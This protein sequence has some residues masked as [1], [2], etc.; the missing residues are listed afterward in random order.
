M[1]VYGTQ[2]YPKIEEITTLAKTF[3]K[4]GLELYMVGGAVRDMVLGRRVKD[5]DFTTNAPPQQ[6]Q[7]LF[8][9]VI[10]TGIDHG[11]VTVLLGK[12][13]FEITTY[14]V[15][16]KYSDQRH[17]DSIAYAGA[18]EEDL[19][20][21]DFTI[22]AM[23]LDPISGELVDLYGGLS[24][25]ESRSIRA[26]GEPA[27]RFAEDPLRVIRGCRFAGQLECTISPATLKAMKEQSIGAISVE[28]IFDELKKTLVT[29]NPALGFAYMGV[30][31][32][33]AEVFPEFTGLDGEFVLP[34]VGCAGIAGK[35]DLESVES[36]S[37]TFQFVN[38]LP[39]EWDIRFTALLLTLISQEKDSSGVERVS[40]IMSRLK[41]S[42][43]EKRRVVHMYQWYPSFVEVVQSGC[44]NGDLRR[45]LVA[46]GSDFLVALTSLVQTLRSELYDKLLTLTS[47]RIP[48]ILGEGFPMSIKEL[49]IGAQ[50]LMQEFSRSPGP[51]IGDLLESLFQATLED[52]TENR[53]D[54]LLTLAKELIQ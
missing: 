17:P 8:R 52:P 25:L 36:L 46:M 37:Q 26:I 5:Y 48:S 3:S 23:A 50:E 42:N 13:H 15:E 6:V 22:N 11:T 10:P 2:N 18:L 53:K 24:D 30:T 27:V 51:W 34:Q 20:R 32:I 16:G 40:R 44:S 29:D 31:G 45:L 9:R 35:S 28:R 54:R 7:K 39:I 19:G 49:E 43:K 33:A 38:I 47:E 21:R 4:E 14:R 41:S 1:R 12:Y